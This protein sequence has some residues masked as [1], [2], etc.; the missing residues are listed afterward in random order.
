MSELALPAAPRKFRPALTIGSLL[1]SIVVLT[2]VL[3]IF[4]L[5]LKTSR[6][7]LRPG[8]LPTDPQPGNYVEAWNRYGLG[9]LFLNSAMVTVGSVIV[10]VMV[11]MSA[12]YAFT[13]IPFKGSEALFSL[14]LLGVVIPP[15]ALV[16]P[17]LIEMRYLGLYDNRA[18]LALVYVAFGLP[19]STLVFRGFFA[20][21]PGELVEAARLDGCT[22]LQILWRIIA[23]MAKG[24]IATVV[25]LMFLANWNEFILALVLLRNA[26]GFTLTLGINAQLGQYTSDY[27]LI[28]AASMIAALPVFLVYLVLQRQ[29]ERGVAE[30]ALKS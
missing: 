5:S 22:E 13:K 16:V 2:P 23:P 18:G 27:H 17:L 25:I 10:T 4:S 29:F 8:L 6:E 11:S 15:S 30:G 1:L 9:Q 28:A 7:T 12:A 3:W 20:T 26:G 21:I 14:L 19:I 24:A